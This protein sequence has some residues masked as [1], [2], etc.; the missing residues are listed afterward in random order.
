[1]DSAKADASG[2][3]GAGMREIADCAGKL[4]VEICGIAGSVD[5]I[6]E[7]VKRE[8]ALFQDLRSATDQTSAGNQRIAAAAQHAREVAER[9][10]GDVE[11]SRAT[12]E[13]SL[14]GIRALV[15]GVGAIES[16]IGGLRAALRKVGKVAEEI[17]AI[18][19][20]TNLLALNATIEAARAGEAGRGFAVVAAEVKGLAGQTAEATKQIE[21][22][23]AE[24]TAQTERLVAD[25]GANV[26]R[27]E[28]VREGTKAIGAANETVGRAMTELGGEAASIAAAAASIGTQCASLVGQVEEMAGGVAQ[29][30]AQLTEVRTRVNHLL[31]VGETLIGLTAE[32]GAETADSPLLA[33]AQQTAA[34]IA[35]AFE[36]AIAAGEIAEADLFDRDYRPIAGSNP[37][38][39][40]TRY[41]AFADRVLPPLQEPVLE[42]DG[43]IVFCCAIDPNGYVP[44]HNLKYSKP[45]GK[46]PLWNAAN[47]RNRRIFGDRTALAAGS[48]MKPVLLQTHRRDMG[49]GK[50]V[51]LKDAAAPILV[52]GRLWGNFHIGYPA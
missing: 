41:T 37:A 5:E 39:V 27:A 28:S 17:A 45:Q 38:Q 51:L 21:A 26:T 24:L 35:A 47:C 15:E 20:Q 29:S 40:T 18:A 49:G 33:A 12:I 3:T 31:H 8:A 44:T 23:L 2:R 22:T 32:S 13:G 30:S 6:S 1:M 46:D 48:N 10:G 25:G 11:A 7:R 4:G 42:L 9:A 36:A 43:R 34:R 50:F 19:R 52:N 16:Q 14:R